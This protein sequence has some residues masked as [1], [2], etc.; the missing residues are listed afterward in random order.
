[1][2][3][4]LLIMNINAK[5]I[6]PNVKNRYPDEE[7]TDHSN[8]KTGS[9]INDRTKATQESVTFLYLSN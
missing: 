5:R 7:T 6:A 8:I 9:V 1:M 4:T 3:A 2:M